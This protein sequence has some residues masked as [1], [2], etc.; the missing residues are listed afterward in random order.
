MFRNWILPALAGVM[1]ALVVLNPA[2]AHDTVHKKALA[3]AV[4]AVPALVLR[5]F[6]GARRSSRAR[7]RSMASV[8]PVPRRRRAG[9]VR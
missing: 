3:V 6:I 1:L 4:I 9:A 8:P 7:A 5:L 2:F